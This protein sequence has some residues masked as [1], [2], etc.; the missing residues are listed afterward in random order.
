MQLTHRGLTIELPDDD[1]RVPIIEALLFGRSLPPAL[2][3][4]PSPSTAPSPSFKDLLPPGYWDFWSALGPLERRE[5]ALLAQREQ[6]PAELERALGLEKDLLRG[7]HFVIHRL[8]AQHH[9]PVRI[10]SR[11]RGRNARLFQL[12]VEVIPFLRLLA[13]HT[14]GP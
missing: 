13:E 5:L 11:G 7:R 6:R 4:P 10:L 1:A 2:A 12:P 9:V 8:A 14:A 3:P